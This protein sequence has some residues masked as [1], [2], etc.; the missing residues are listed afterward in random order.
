MISIRQERWC[1]LKRTEIFGKDRAWKWLSLARQVVYPI[2]CVIFVLR[3]SGLSHAEPQGKLI[4]FHAGSLAIP[5]KD[6]E[7]AFTKKYPKIQVCREAAGSRI[8]ARK[9]SDLN[10]PCDVMA[11]ADYTVI[12]QLLIP[13]WADWNLGF[14][15][16]EMAI[17]YRADSKFADEI[18]QKNWYRIL[19]RPEVEYG[20][21]DP[22]ADP[23]G[24]RSQLVWQLAERYYKIPGLYQRL[25]ENCPPSNVRPKEVDLIA[26]LEAG[27]IDYLFIYRS[28]CEQHE[29]PY[30]I[31]PDQINLGSP[32]YTEYYKQAR[33]KVTGKRP[34]EWIEKIGA[35]MI[36]GITIPKN[37]P[38]HEAALAF[39][40]FVLGPIGRK[41]MVKNGQPPLVPPM[42][43][44]RKDL[45]PQAIREVLKTCNR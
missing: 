16:N 45:L 18:N 4:I 21:S 5:F 3:V 37:A 7:E 26:M 8:C 29:S 43:T 32:E 33:I 31:L 2:L 23:C 12:D 25:Q 22:N 34:G 27:Q 20:H 1:S 13:E 30:L 35:P 40:R 14:C 19:L 28:V 41:I 10:R 39:V 15:T 11:S 36:Y 17:M 38:N 42:L 6:M 44:G 9:I 24:Y